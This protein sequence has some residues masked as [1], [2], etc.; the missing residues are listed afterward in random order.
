M[1]INTTESVVKKEVENEVLIQKHFPAVVYLDQEKLQETMH[2]QTKQEFFFVN[3]FHFMRQGFQMIVDDNFNK[4][5]E[6]K[7]VKPWNWNLFLFTLWIIGFF[8]RYLI[9]FPFRFIIFVSM[10]AFFSITF[11]SSS[12][13]PKTKTKVA[14][15][16]W[17]L[18]RFG[19]AW[20]TSLGCVVRYHGKLPPHKPNM[21]YVC[22]HTTLFDYMILSSRYPFGLVGQI[23]PGW[24]GFLQ[25]RV[26]AFVDNIWF[27]RSM[28]SEKAF[29]NQKIK[30]HIADPSNARLL[31][32]P[33][34]TCVNNKYCIMFK[35]GAFEIGATVV[36]IAIKY[37]KI[38]CDPFWNSRKVSFFRYC[39]NLMSSWMMIVDVWFLEPTQ[40]QN[41]ENAEQHANRVKH[42]ICDRA[43]LIPTNWD[44]YMKHFQL[45]Q[46][47]VEEQ[48][49]RFCEEMVSAFN[50]GPMNRRINSEEDNNINRSE[51]ITEFDG[52]FEGD[53]GTDATDQTD[54]QTEGGEQTDTT[55]ES[56]DGSPKQKKD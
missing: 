12:F 4:C 46:R 48:Q 35:K 30:D 36:P 9:I 20:L 15:E 7:R 11:V 22:N 26:I 24:I 34:G 53:D 13:L 40:L 37:H 33:E 38:F 27:D 42:M 21:I 43:H 19:D 45:S 41:D 51:S 5:F 56:E 1:A 2:F 16:R 50:Q 31:M 54:E 49:N 17:L 47:F 23:H 14:I 28:R 10:L 39:L 32:F 52:E 8:L 55:E 25:K 6:P 18:L 44:G 3:S 29:V